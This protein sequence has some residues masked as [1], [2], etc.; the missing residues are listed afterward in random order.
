M[1][2]N[3]AP[4][5]GVLPLPPAAIRATFPV[6]A[7]RQSRPRRHPQLRQ[8]RYSWA[9]AVSEAE[10]RGLHERFH[11]AAPGKPIFQA[12][13]ANLNPGTE[14]RGRHRATP[15]AGRC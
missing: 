12:A 1:A 4:F 14:L 11:V 13:V 15:T 8:F 9:N 5:R 10:A 6:L 2:V 3:P 7:I